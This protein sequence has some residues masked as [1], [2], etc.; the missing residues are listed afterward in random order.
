MY[1]GEG[2][3]SILYYAFA[4]CAELQEI[5]FPNSLRY[6][7]SEAFEWCFNLK[8]IVFNGSKEE[9]EKKSFSSMFPE[10]KYNIEF[11]AKD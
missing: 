1:L 3:N 11:L 6:V 2:I 5:H 10:S 7:D 4:N 9:W 8:T